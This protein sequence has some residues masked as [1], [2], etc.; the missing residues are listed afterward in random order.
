MKRI[1][2]FLFVFML[3]ALAVIWGVT[4]TTEIFFAPD[5]KPTV[6]LIQE[7]QN[8]KK[9]IYV[10]VYMITALPIAKELVAAKQRGVDV[11][12]IT[13][14]AS[15]DSPSGK[16]H[17]LCAAGIPV[18]VFMPEACASVPVITGCDSGSNHDLKFCSD[19][20]GKK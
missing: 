4:A 6:R 19:M 10:A 2:K 5:D 20:Y 9:K 1:K 16:V 7:L 12:V 8:A 18:R 17:F 11:Q 3:P 15:A 14:V 13:D